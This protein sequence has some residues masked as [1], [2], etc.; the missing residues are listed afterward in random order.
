MSTAET[1]TLAVSS[2]INYHQMKKSENNQV[3]LQNCTMYIRTGIETCKLWIYAIC[4][5]TV[6]IT[7]THTHKKV[8]D[9]HSNSDRQTMQTLFGNILNDWHHFQEFTSFRTNLKSIRMWNGSP[10]VTHHLKAYF[11]K[12]FIFEIHMSIV[13]YCV[14]LKRS[15]QYNQT[16]V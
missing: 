14:Y 7:Y 6:H 13:R 12:K 11:P 4:M 15:Y 3:R 2:A 10:F 9:W 8:N 1:C 16:T 5:Y